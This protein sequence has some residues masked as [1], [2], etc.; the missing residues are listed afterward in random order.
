MSAV[1]GRLWKI[2]AMTTAS[3]M[4]EQWAFF[5]RSSLATAPAQAGPD[6]RPSMVPSS[7]DG[8]CCGRMCDLWSR[9]LGRALRET[10]RFGGAMVGSRAA[11]D[12]AYGG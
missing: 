3:T 4:D 5:M 12:P 2:P 11:L 1:A 8:R 6:A 7:R 10:Q 9:R